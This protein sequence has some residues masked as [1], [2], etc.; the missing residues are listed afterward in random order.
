MEEFENVCNENLVYCLN[1]I[2]MLISKVN[3]YNTTLR[4]INKQS[5]A[6]NIDTL[7]EDSIVISELENI[8]ALYSKLNSD[9]YNNDYEIDRVKNELDSKMQNLEDMIDAEIARLNQKHNEDI[10]KKAVQYIYVSRWQNKQSE[11]KYLDY[12]D[13]FISKL[14]GEAKY[15]KLSIEKKKLE[16]DLIKKEYEEK[17]KSYNGENPREVAI[18]LNNEPSYSLELWRFKEK[19]VSVFMITDMPSKHSKNLEWRIA[20]M[21]PYGFF[22]KIRYYK[23]LNK[24]EE[25]EIESLK[26]KLEKEE[27]LEE[28]KKDVFKNI[29]SLKE[30]NSQIKSLIENITIAG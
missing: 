9:F 2:N 12:K 14:T 5:K 29:E 20:N 15:R 7:E 22:E 19:I 1:K 28:A 8:K 25:A 17:V 16:S 26:S 10:F 6:L 4:I 23:S 18:M 21:L 30:I 13:T 24:N 27:S 3:K 11:I